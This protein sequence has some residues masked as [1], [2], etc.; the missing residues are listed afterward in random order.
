MMIAS[1][2]WPLKCSQ[3]FPLIWPGDLVFDPKWPIFKLDLEIIMANILSSIYDDCFKNVTSRVLRSFSFDLTRWPIFC[4]PKWPRRL[5]L[6]FIGANILGKF[7]QDWVKT[8][9]LPTVRKTSVNNPNI[10]SISS[11]GKNMRPQDSA[12]GIFKNPDLDL[13]VPGRRILHP[14]EPWIYHRL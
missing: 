14:Q 2:M 9:M 6:D 11:T 8:V 7:H 13:C 5:D 1:K 12:L 10:I 4:P 3:G